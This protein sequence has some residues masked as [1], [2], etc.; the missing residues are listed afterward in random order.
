M[1]ACPIARTAMCHGLKDELSQTITVEVKVDVPDSADAR[2]CIEQYYLELAERFDTGFDPIK[3]N[4]APDEDLVPP[5][6]YFVVARLDGH[7]VGCGVLKRKNPTTG[8]IKRMWTAS[9]PHAGGVLHAKFSI[10]LRPLLGKRDLQCSILKRIGPS[11]RPRHCTE[12]K[13]ISK[14]TPSTRNLTP[15]IGSRNTYSPIPAD[16]RETP[17][18]WSRK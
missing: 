7:P 15:I 4:P 14:S 2:W 13:D 6:G 16:D 1:A 8:E 10:R 12:R 9:H 5:R 11:P 3:S 17:S 18:E